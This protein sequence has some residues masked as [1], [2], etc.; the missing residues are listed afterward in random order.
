MKKKY[1]YILLTDTG[2]LFSKTIKQYTKAPYNHASIAFDLNLNEMYSFGRRNPRNPINSGFVKEDVLEGI[3]RAFPQTK[4]V[5]YKFE[6]DEEKI[7]K[8]K[9]IIDKFEKN[10]ELYYYNLLGIVGVAFN[11]PIE[12]R[13]SFFCSQFVGE[14]LNR[15]GVIYWDKRT[16]L[17]TPNDFR[18][19]P[20]FEV[21]FEGMLF[22]YEPIKSRILVQES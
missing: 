12:P 20:G 17:V 9:S 3:Y 22:E 19:L 16:S 18:N 8:M 15:A 1:I 7:E 2:T 13:N 10:K 6:V 4:C 11:E 14:V 21:V 5:L